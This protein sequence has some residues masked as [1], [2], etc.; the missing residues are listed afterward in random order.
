MKRV[1]FAHIVDLAVLYGV[2]RVFRKTAVMDTA[3]NTIIMLCEGT[4]TDLMPI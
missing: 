2:W 3:P 1:V 4:W